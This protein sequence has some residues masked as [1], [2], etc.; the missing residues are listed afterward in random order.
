MESGAFWRFG[1]PVFL[2]GFGSV[3]LRYSG[4]LA[5]DVNRRARAVESG[6]F[7]LFGTPVFSVP[8]ARAMSLPGVRQAGGWVRARMEG[9]AGRLQI[10]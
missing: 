5:P 2:C 6:F 4:A 8:L 9:C 7:W 3:R 1:T 10:S